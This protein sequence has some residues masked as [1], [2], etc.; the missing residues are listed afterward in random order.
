MSSQSESKILPRDLVIQTKRSALLRSRS[1]VERLSFVP[2][3]L[4]LRRS[5]SVVERLPSPVPERPTLKR[6]VSRAEQMKRKRNLMIQTKLSVPSRTYFETKRSRS[7]T[8]SPRRGRSLNKITKFTRS[9]SRC[10]TLMIITNPL[11]RFNHH[12]KEDKKENK[13]DKKYRD[14]SVLGLP[15]CSSPRF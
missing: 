2:G 1:V 6:S 13:E 7:E 11:G 15:Q 10:Y 9:I 3:R 8:K 4:V 14:V 5:R 12:K